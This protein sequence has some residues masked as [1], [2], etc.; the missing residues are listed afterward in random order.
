MRKLLLL[1]LPVI[2]LTGCSHTYYV[3]RHAEKQA[4]GPGMTSDVPLSPQGELR[5]ALLARQLGGKKIAVIYSTKTQRTINTAKPLADELGLNIIT[6]GPR[7]DSNFIKLLLGQRKNILIVGHSN[8]VDEIV[9]GLM[10]KKVI[11]ADLPET[12]YD[13]LF[14]IRVKGKRTR[15]T[16]K[17]MGM[18][19]E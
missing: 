13:N 8:T 3:V 12:A 7:P 14:E 11:P 2:F 18:E 5:A 9:N 1:L 19:G 15:F 4:Q 16:R 6:Y 17:R 10:K